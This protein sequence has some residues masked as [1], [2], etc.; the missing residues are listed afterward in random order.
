M[1]NTP[2]NITPEIDVEAQWQKFSARHLPHRHRVLPRWAVAACFCLVVGGTLAMTLPRLLND[3]PQVQP[4]SAAPALSEVTSQDVV[5]AT[6]FVF[7]DVSL[8]Q[9]LDTLSAYYHVNIIYI[10][11]EA[12]QLR[13]YTQLEKDLMLSEAVS[14]LNQLGGLSLRIENEDTLLVE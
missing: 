8:Q 1:N 2:A 5:A 3:Q 10:N 12:V 13:L 14:L 7:H 4:Q 9:V 11:K 6:S